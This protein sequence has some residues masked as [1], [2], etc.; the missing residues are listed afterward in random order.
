VLLFNHSSQ[1]PIVNWVGKIKHKHAGRV[2]ELCG[3]TLQVRG[4][5]GAGGRKVWTKC[6]VSTWLH[7]STTRSPQDFFSSCQQQL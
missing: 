7:L 1:Q 5:A 6:G 2:V 3:V 4:G